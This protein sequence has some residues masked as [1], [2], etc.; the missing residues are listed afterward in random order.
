MIQPGDAE[1]PNNVI[2]LLAIR[3]PQYIDAD[4]RVFKRPLRTSDST[5][6]VGLFPSLKVPEQASWEIGGG[7]D[8]RGESTIKRYTV[9]A[10]SYVMDSDEERAI[11]TH[12]ILAN[13]LWRMWH[14]DNPLHVALTA[15]Q[16]V[17]NNTTE[18]FQRRGATST[19]YLSNE[20]QGSFL[21]TS[22][23]EFWFDTET[24]R[25]A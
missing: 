11:S 20:I 21:Q 16:V 17:A 6:T 2:S 9:I 24:V 12:S 5:Q 23:I 4:L 14:W 18:R 25:N 1:F 7:A 19:R 3:A 15:L 8:T 10:Q 13:R 22:W